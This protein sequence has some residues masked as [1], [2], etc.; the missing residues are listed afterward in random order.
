MTELK[1]KAQKLLVEHRKL[2]VK[3]RTH[4]LNSNSPWSVSK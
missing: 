3:N 1:T 4:R 2:L